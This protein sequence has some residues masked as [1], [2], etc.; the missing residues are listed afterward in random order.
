M[1]LSSRLFYGNKDSLG[2]EICFICITVRSSFMTQ[3]SVIHDDTRFRVGT[4]VYS[5]AGLVTLFA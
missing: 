1:I 4:L 5:R 2:Y 3:S